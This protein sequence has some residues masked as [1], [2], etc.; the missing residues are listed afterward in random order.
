MTSE[1]LKIAKELAE[2]VVE[3][4]DDDVPRLLAYILLLLLEAKEQAHGQ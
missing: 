3:G 2:A 4:K 1:E